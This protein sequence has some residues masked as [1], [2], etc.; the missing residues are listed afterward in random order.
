MT[1]RVAVSSV[2][3]VI[4]GGLAGYYGGWIDNITQR[5]IEVL[6]RI[7]TRAVVLHGQQQNVSIF[8]KLHLN[9]TRLRMTS[10]VGQGFLSNPETCG[11][12]FA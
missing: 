9:L 11:F 2:L 3:G 4:L 5:L 1:P 6:R 8:R 10:D 7:E 12:T